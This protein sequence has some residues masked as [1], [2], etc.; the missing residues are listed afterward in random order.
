M[1]FKTRGFW[2]A[3]SQ[4]SGQPPPMML[5]IL[6]PRTLGSLPAR[7]SLLVNLLVRDIIVGFS[8]A[9]FGYNIT[10]LRPNR[11]PTATVVLQMKI[12]DAADFN[13]WGAATALCIPCAEI[14]RGENKIS[15]S[16]RNYVRLA[17]S[18]SFRKCC[19]IPF[20]VEFGNLQRFDV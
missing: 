13:D 18:Q 11:V 20:A 15:C 17:S 12:T 4:S 7:W 10:G 14:A 1:V 9:F 6:L 16:L 8:K 3:T 2:I 5:E 19:C